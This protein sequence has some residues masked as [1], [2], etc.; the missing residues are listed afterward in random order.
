[1][2]KECES[3]HSDSFRIAR[4]LFALYVREECVLCENLSILYLLRINFHRAR[5]RR[6]LQASYVFLCTK[7]FFFLFNF[8]ELELLCKTYLFFFFILILFQINVPI[9]LCL[10]HVKTKKKHEFFTFQCDF[11]A[12]FDKWRIYA[13]FLSN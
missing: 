7:P 13:I 12:V 9:Y 3:P 5:L 2:R 4:W 1:M 6:R 11:L 8:L 10:Y